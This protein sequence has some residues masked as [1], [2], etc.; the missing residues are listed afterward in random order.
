MASLQQ[1]ANR[2]LRAARLAPRAVGQGHR[3]RLVTVRTVHRAR[4]ERV[5]VGVLSAGVPASL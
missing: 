5:P 4:Y 2:T 3:L 1:R